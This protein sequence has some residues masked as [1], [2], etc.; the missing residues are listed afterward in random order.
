[1]LEMFE[2]AARVRKE[3]RQSRNR[4]N[5]MPDMLGWR[6]NR[7]CYLVSVVLAPVLAVMLLAEVLR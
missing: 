1:M 5:G 6:I 3:V 7:L 4:V 2:A